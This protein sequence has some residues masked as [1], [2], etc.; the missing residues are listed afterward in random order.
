MV[1]AAPPL[2]EGA[3]PPRGC[4]CARLQVFPRQTAIG[5]RQAAA[6]QAT[7]PR[8]GQVMAFTSASYVA[9]A[10]TLMAAFAQLSQ[11]PQS[12]P[13]YTATQ[14]ESCVHDWS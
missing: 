9:F 1:P 8:A 4:H 13:E 10:E 2:L 11:G 3:P 14:S 12:A 5:A 6:A 7:G